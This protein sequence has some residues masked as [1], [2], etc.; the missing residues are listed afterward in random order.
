MPVKKDI[1][2]VKSK[3]SDKLV[4]KVTWKCEGNYV[5]IYG[6][7]KRY[8]KRGFNSESEAKEWERKFL[9]SI[10]E[11]PESK[12][13][14]NDLYTLFLDNRKK[15]VKVSTYNDIIYN[16]KKLILPFWKDIKL[17]KINIRMIEEWQKGMVDATFTKNGIE[18][19]YSNNR[20]DQIQTQF[21]TIMKYGS[22]IGYVTNAQLFM[23]KNMK[24]NDEM[25]K[26]MLFWTPDEYNKFIQKV[27]DPYYYA[28]F[29]VLYW[30]GLRLGEALALTWNDIDLNTKTIKITK[31][32]NGHQHLI[33]PP[34]TKNSNRSVIMTDKCYQSIIHIYDLQSQCEGFTK[35]CYLFG[36]DKP[37]D[38]NT[39]RRRKNEACAVADVKQ[40]RIHDFRH[41]H[42]SLLINLNFSAFDI[43]K[44]L[45]HTVDMV[46]NTYGHWFDNAQKNM[47]DKLNKIA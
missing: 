29:N 11:S 45:G 1:R 28:L 34:K 41:S 9:I 4:K 44:R 21:K 3:K 35:D 27:D 6:N 25:K 43:A 26:E 13:T 30:C 15:F 36:F 17:S 31:T 20:L 37:F 32:Y 22:Q 12:M 47:V 46:N 19:H 14:F 16:C 40:I 18:K 38:D 5:D 42:V 10:K 2:K 33:T 8:H 24:R 23:F 39:V 7:P